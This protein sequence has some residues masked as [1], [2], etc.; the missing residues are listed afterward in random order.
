MRDLPV[1]LT[2]DSL[3]NLD[4]LV[5]IDLFINDSNHDADVILPAL[6][7]A[8]KEGTVTNLEGR[9]MKVNQITPGPG[10][11]RPDWSILDD[12]A[13]KLGSPIGLSSARAIAKEIEAVAPAYAG[14]TWERLE[15]DD[16]DGVVAPDGDT[17]PL[18]SFVPVDVDLETPSHETVLHLARTLYDDGVLVRRGPSLR[19]LAPG[20]FCGMRTEHAE[21]LGV[22]EGDLVTVTGAVGAIDVPVRIDDSLVAGTV[23]VPFNQPA[24]EPIGDRLSVYVKAA[25]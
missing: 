7:F 3:A 11:A 6:G 24:L 22:T 23:H 19:P 1:G 25:R 9:V 12:L 15:W 16:P 8:E 14:I 21:Q 13:S 18:L 4:L 10:Q 5:S 2:R 17:G 20:G